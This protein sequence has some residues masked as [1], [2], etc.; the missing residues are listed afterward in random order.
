MWRS[1]GHVE[2]SPF[3]PLGTVR[4]KSALRVGDPLSLQVRSSNKQPLESAGLIRDTPFTGDLR[5]LNRNNFGIADPLAGWIRLPPH[6]NSC[7]RPAVPIG[8]SPQ[9]TCLRVH[10]QR[11]GPAIRITLAATVV[12]HAKI[13]RFSENHMGIPSRLSL[14]VDSTRGNLLVPA[15]SLTL[16]K[17]R[18]LP[19]F[20]CGEKSIPPLCRRS[21]DC[22]SSRI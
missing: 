9:R 16:S 3:F 13:C 1:S 14:G 22:L 17:P 6:A 4:A 15:R 18:F 5:Q 21:F 19:R 8:V 7:M 12:T 10:L 2:I 11:W 20:V